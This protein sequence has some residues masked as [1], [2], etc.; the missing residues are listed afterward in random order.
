MRKLV[1]TIALVLASSI[2]IAPTA[3]AGELEAQVHALEYLK[4]AEGQPESYLDAI[5]IARKLLTD[6]PKLALDYAGSYCD[7]T[8]RGYSFV[9][10][11]NYIYGKLS[12]KLAGQPPLAFAAGSNVAAGGFAYAI[13]RGCTQVRRSQGDLHP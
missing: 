8:D 4:Y 13:E 12:T 1:L 10:A 11:T 3:K 7:L 6:S 5:L 9:E 2:A